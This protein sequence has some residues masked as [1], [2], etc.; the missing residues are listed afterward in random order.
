MLMTWPPCSFLNSKPSISLKSGL[1]A[2]VAP[3]KPI[4]SSPSS[5]KGTFSISHDFTSGK[6]KISSI[7]WGPRRRRVSRR[8]KQLV[9]REVLVGRLI[10]AQS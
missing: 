1:K 10:H 3:P 6:S 4:T 7:F 8:V 9:E 2:Y 5:M